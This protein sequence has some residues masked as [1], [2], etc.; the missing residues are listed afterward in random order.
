MLC[1]CRCQKTVKD[2]FFF[3]QMNVKACS[4]EHHRF[5]LYDIINEAIEKFTKNYS[6]I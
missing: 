3:K 6:F 2:P 4:G 1:G 5:P